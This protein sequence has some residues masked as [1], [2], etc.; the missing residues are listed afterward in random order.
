MSQVEQTLLAPTPSH[1]P[2]RA[3][4]RFPS[5]EPKNANILVS[6]VMPCL[7]EARTVAACIDQ[8]R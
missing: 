4:T 5:E 6:V 1:Q 2:H 8:P 3:S 7:N